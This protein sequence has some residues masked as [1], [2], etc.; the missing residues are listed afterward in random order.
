MKHFILKFALIASMLMTM[1]FTNME[2][3]PKPAVDD[4][5][6]AV[7]SYYGKRFHGRLTASGDV[8][9]MNDMTCAHKTLKFGTKV[10]FTNPKNG[11]SIIVTVNDRGPYIKGRKFDLSKAAFAKIANINQGV[12]KL[13]YKI[14]K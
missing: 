1:S 11:K 10:E 14:L 13:K 8:F 6:D 7:V 4:L 9:D 12:A 5:E 2:V 3:T